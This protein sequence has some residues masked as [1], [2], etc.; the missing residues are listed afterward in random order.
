MSKLEEIEQERNQCLE[1]F[2]ERVNYL[3][4]RNY[5]ITYYETGHDFFSRGNP[6]RMVQPTE[7]MSERISLEEIP[8]WLKKTRRGF[9]THPD[10]RHGMTKR[11]REE[12]PHEEKRF[13]M[14]VITN[15]HKM[16]EEE[17]EIWD[18]KEEVKIR[19]TKEKG[20]LV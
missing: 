2:K 11:E 17:E 4:Q 13:G 3:T 10:L 16:T 9:W 7:I 12:I 5:V 19:D 8:E 18:I 1:Q 15:I 20:G 6:E 14:V